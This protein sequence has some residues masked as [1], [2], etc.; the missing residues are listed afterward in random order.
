[1]NE[2]KNNVSTMYQTIPA[3]AAMNHVPGFEPMKLL[4]RTKSRKG[5][6]VVWKLALPYKKLWFRLVN[7]NGRI[8]LN[9]L[10]V[11]E[12]MAVYE[13]QVFLDRNEQFYCQLYQRGYDS[14]RLYSGSP[15]GGYR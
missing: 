5:N 9:A 8:K 13:A 14:G 12:Q 11:T 6:E 10:S 15:G 3:V 2:S 1:M 7:P 4:R